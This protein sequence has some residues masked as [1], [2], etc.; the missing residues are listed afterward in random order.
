MNDVM[1]ISASDLFRKPGVLY[2]YLEKTDQPVIL[3]YRHTPKAVILRPDVYSALVS[4]KEQR[5]TVVEKIIFDE[6]HN[7]DQACPAKQHVVSKAPF[8]PTD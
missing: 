7:P 1:V 3:K 5:S 4:A 6:I 8:G 2:E